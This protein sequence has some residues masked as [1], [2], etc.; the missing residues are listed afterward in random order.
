MT[1]GADP[2]GF[3]D[4][5]G[6]LALGSVAFQEKAKGWVK[7]VTKEQPMRKCLKSGVGIA[8]IVRLVED[9]RGE[10]WAEFAN[11]HADWGRELVIYLA[12][13]RTGL[14]LKQIGEALGGLEYKTTGKA[15]Q[16][17]E[18]SL[19]TNGTRRK[20]THSLLEQMSLVE[21]RPL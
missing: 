10:S 11:R 2:E 3:E 19:A 7:K 4:F 15:V 6:R 18:A 8:T 12:R 21:I 20:L 5:R 13:K 9:E 16:R 14:T 17:F 1:R